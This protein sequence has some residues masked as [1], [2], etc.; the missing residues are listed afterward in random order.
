MCIWLYRIALDFVNAIDPLHDPVTWY[1][2]TYTGDR[3]R[4]LFQK[5]ISRIF[6]GL[7]QGSDWFFKG[8]KIHINPYTLNISMLILLN[9]SIHIIFLVQFNWF[10]E[11]SRTD[12]LFPEL[13]SPGK[14]HIKIPGFSRF[15][16]TRT[17]PVVSK[18][19]SG[20]YVLQKY[21]NTSLC[22]WVKISI[23]HLYT[24][25]YALRKT[26]Q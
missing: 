22:Y 23:T 4:T 24:P 12:G 1:K 10:P 16:R 21:S 25:L 2:I 9:V 15:S 26:Y 3:V 17:N 5:Q 7:F 13:S 11:L 18:L 19:R 20:T 8:S 14:C 6:P